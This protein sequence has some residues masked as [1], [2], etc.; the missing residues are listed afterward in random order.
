MVRR[1]VEPTVN[2]ISTI[3]LLGT[4]LLIYVADRVARAGGPEATPP[5]RHGR[6]TL[7]R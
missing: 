2:A 3:I 4:S 7:S 1:N 5:D 6:S